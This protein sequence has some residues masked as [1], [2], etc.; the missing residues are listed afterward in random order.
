MMIKRNNWPAGL[1]LVLIGLTA[2]LWVSGA[3]EKRVEQVNMVDAFVLQEDGALSWFSLK[4]E[5]EKIHF[6]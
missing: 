2:F 3:S 1:L 5:S 4:K 6:P